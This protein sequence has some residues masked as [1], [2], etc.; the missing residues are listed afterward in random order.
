[1]SKPTAGSKDRRVVL[2]LLALCAIVLM[3]SIGHALVL[4]IIDSLYR[5]I[6][7]GEYYVDELAQKPGYG[8][9]Y[10]TMGGKPV[11]KQNPTFDR[12][13]D[14]APASTG[15]LIRRMRRGDLDWGQVSVFDLALWCQVTGLYKE[16][17][18]VLGVQRIVAESDYAQVAES[19]SRWEANGRPVIVEDGVRL[20]VLD[21]YP[22]YDEV[23]T[24]VK[25][26]AQRHSGRWI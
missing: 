22:D 1:M 16:Y 13:I 25:K 11:F 4:Q 19:W 20:P 10:H 17:V 15:P 21:G 18:P 7:P 12:V 5:R 8:H 24:A 6:W 3:A 26:V 23:V 9:V 2:V 14:L